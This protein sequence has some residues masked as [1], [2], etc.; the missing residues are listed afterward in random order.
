V[1]VS[2]SNPH[3]HRRRLGVL[4]QR[5]QVELA[6]QR[7]SRFAALEREYAGQLN[8]AGVRLVRASTFTAYCDCRALG[9]AKRADQILDRAGLPPRSVAGRETVAAR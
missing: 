9:M 8:E 2:A 5:A 7:L 6:L 3:H 1:D 4:S